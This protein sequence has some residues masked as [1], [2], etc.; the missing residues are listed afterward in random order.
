MRNKLI[1]FALS[2]M[3]VLTFIPQISFAL[4]EETES[5]DSENVT[6]EEQATEPIEETID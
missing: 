1:S 4:E 3:L 2:A 6:I 5:P